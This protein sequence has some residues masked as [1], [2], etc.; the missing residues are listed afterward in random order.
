MKRFYKDV[1]VAPGEGGFCIL[2]DGKPV[3]TPARGAL[4]L[5][6]ESLALAIAQEWRD[7]GET[8][9]AT[10]MPLL[11][12]A[13][14][15]IDGVAKNRTDVITAILRFGENDLLCYRAHQPPDLAARQGEAWDPLLDWVRQRHSAHM[16]VAEGLGHV[17]QTLDALA[18]LREPLEDLDA[19]TL[20][21]LHVIAS[22]TG[23]LVLAL[24]VLEGYVPGAYA[25]E[26][27]RID[28]TYQ[29]KKWGEDAEAQKRATMLAHE[30]DKAVELIAA[31]R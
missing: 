5:P 14:T 11:R 19:F 4:A 7:Q 3:K 21:G 18:A 17:D 6:T 12:L 29:A 16:K 30:L 23:S 24:A 13:N 10:T 31:V 1:S 20:A 25:F 26:L 15:V 22:I 2:L 27:S 8:I 9:V 28:E